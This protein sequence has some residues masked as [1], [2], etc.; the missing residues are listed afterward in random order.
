[1]DDL[2]SLMAN[3]TV[4]FN[5]N[6][7]RESIQNFKIFWKKKLS[8]DRRL[9]KE[10]AVKKMTIFLLFYRL[11]QLL[12]KTKKLWALKRNFIASLYIRGL[13][14]GPTVKTMSLSFF[15]FSPTKIDGLRR[16]G[17]RMIH[18]LLPQFYMF[19]V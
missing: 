5:I 13:G 6:I 15:F 1:M 4:Q 12:S 16:F 7:F 9:N 14:F 17:V 11:L 3:Q 18:D 19:L 8:L 10:R 2:E